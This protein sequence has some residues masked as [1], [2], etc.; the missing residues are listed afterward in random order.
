MAEEAIFW[1]W[2][3][4]NTVSLVT[5]T[6]VYHW[7]VEGDSQPV[8]MFDRHASLAGYQMIHY[9]TDKNQEWLLLIGISAQVADAML[10]NQMFTHYDRAH[11]AQL[12][13]KAGL[14]QQALEHYTDL[15]DIKRTLVHAHL[16]NPE[17]LVSFF[18]SL[19]VEDSVECLRAMLSAN[20]RQNL[21]LCMQVASKYHEQLGTQSLVQLFESFRSYEG[22]FYFLGSIV[23]F[24]QDPDVHLKYIQAACKTGQIKEVEQI[25]RESSCYDPE[26]VKNFLKEAKLTDQL[27]L[28]IV[29]DRFDFVHD[30][31]LY[32]YRNSLQKYIEIYVQ[33]VNPSQTPAVVGGLLDMD[34]SEEVIKNLIMAV[35]GQFSTDE[36]VAEVEKKK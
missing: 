26:H 24:S 11:I 2:V 30:L 8:K 4:V 34:C 13:E 10:G 3:S 33:K 23:N 32:L 28:I 20:I 15:Y 1:K 21:Q 35:R 6:T 9:R 16:L 18:G 19:S 31:I 29:C 7:S 36:L 22:L 12:C 27:P 5:E 25:W 14:L 17:W